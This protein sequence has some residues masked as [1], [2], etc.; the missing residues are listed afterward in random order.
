MGTTNAT[1]A[2]E[3]G[4][5]GPGVMPAGRET[6]LCQERFCM[7]RVL[8]PFCSHILGAVFTWQFSSHFFSVCSSAVANYFSRIN[9]RFLSRF[10][11]GG[12]GY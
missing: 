1:H 10:R 2:C 8:A 7:S 6:L 12:K 11:R 3:L 5:V 9:S 4:S